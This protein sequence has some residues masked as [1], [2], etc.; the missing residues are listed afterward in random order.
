MREYQHVINYCVHT[1]NY[2]ISILPICVVNIVVVVVA[3]V[4]RVTTYRSVDVNTVTVFYVADV[5]VI[6]ILDSSF[7]NESTFGFF[8]VVFGVFFC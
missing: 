4:L 6:A 7:Y 1:H 2:C 3:V 8:V 5:V